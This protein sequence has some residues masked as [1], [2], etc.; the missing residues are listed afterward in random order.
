MVWVDFAE[1]GRLCG[2]LGVCWML[3]GLISEDSLIPGAPVFSSSSVYANPFASQYRI[4][5]NEWTDTSTIAS[6]G[7]TGV[8]EESTAADHPY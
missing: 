5:G 3:W 2:A 1:M 6:N 7:E 4:S 8:C